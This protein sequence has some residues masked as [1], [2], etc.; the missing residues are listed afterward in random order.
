[1]LL[2]WVIV[3]LIVLFL[4]APIIVVI[5]GSFSDQ[6]YL[7]FPPRGLS[8][9]WYV[10]ALS[11]REFMNSAAVSLELGVLAASAS[12]VIGIMAALGTTGQRGRWT[13]VL[14]AVLSA[15]LLVPGIVIGIAMLFYFTDIH[16][17]GTFAALVL[18]HTVLTLPYVVRSVA[19]GL[20]TIDRSAEEAARSLGAGRLRATMTITLP[21]IKGNVLAGVAFAFII[22]FDEVVV[23][24]FLASPRITTLPVRIYN[25]IA[26]T[27]D[28]SIAAISTMMIV[29]TTALV[30][31]IDRYVGFV[32]LF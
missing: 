1:V 11:S 3:G 14:M 15:P 9:R 10:Q 19:A 5:I 13:D 26:Y 12:T 29:A 21:M 27:S 17:G 25:Y 16:L 6:A 24:L 7:V 31:V 23:T 2:W 4:L 30:L 18:A 32:R 20:E 8:V 22:S 28:P